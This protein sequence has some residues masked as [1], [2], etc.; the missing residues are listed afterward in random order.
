VVVH[1][2]KVMHLHYG[3]LVFR[4]RL[5]RRHDNPHRFR[6]QIGIMGQVCRVIGDT[7][8]VCSVFAAIRER[9]QAQGM[10]VCSANAYIDKDIAGYPEYPRTKRSS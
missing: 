5:Y 1:V 4:K 2:I 7:I 3:P 6:S 10:M 9:V 8:E